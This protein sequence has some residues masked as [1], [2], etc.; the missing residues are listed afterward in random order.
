MNVL[1]DFGSITL[2][3]DGLPLTSRRCVAVGSNGLQTKPGL[4]GS[5]FATGNSAGLAVVE[6]GALCP[7]R[8]VADPF[9]PRPEWE[10]ARAV[11]PSEFGV[12]VHATSFSN[13]ACQD[14]VLPFKI[15]GWVK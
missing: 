11:R 6:A 10:V 9:T 7:R 8:K 14:R 3:P 1:P 15:A 5:G 2:L 4:L 12:S 13:P